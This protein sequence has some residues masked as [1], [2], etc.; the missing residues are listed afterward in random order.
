MTASL[1]ILVYASNSNTRTA[2]T[3]AIGTQPDSRLPAFEYLEVASEPMV[4]HYLDA[5]GIDLAILDGEATPAGGMGVAKQLKDEIEHCPPLVVLTGR[6]DDRWLADWSGAEAAVSHPIDPFV[7]TRAVTD[8]LSNR[9]N[10]I[11]R[12]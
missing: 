12:K 3:T 9:S 4:V 1:R 2:V 7:L 5:G 10:S 11:G 6:P 8:L